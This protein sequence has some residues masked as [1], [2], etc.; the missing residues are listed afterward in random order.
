MKFLKDSRNN[1]VLYKHS[2]NAEKKIK[3]DITMADIFKWFA[4]AS[5]NWDHSGH[6]DAGDVLNLIGGIFEAL[7]F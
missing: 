7:G 6:N 1:C 3:G 5:G 2:S 4:K